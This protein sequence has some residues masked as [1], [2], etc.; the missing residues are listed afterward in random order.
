MVKVLAREMSEHLEILPTRRN[1]FPY[2]F[3]SGLPEI[4]TINFT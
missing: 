2:T 4:K 1:L 3:E